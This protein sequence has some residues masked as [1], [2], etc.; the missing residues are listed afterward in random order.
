MART[1]ISH[2][3]TDVNEWADGLQI[4]F[5]AFVVFYRMIVRFVYLDPSLT[6]VRAAQSCTRSLLTDDYVE[7]TD[8]Y[9]HEDSVDVRTID[10][11]IQH[12]WL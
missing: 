11:C 8:V 7:D 1:S 6:C 2:L 4:E 9:T 3:L 12:L 5:S 10:S